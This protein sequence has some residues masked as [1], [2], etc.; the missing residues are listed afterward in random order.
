[1]VVGPI[2]YTI[3]NIM[4]ALVGIASISMNKRVTARPHAPPSDTHLFPS[5]IH[6]AVHGVN[7]FCSLI[8]TALKLVRLLLNVVR[9]NANADGHR[10]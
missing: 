6:G 4:H 2:P 1:M 9:N 8:V 7:R 10:E 5:R 3:L